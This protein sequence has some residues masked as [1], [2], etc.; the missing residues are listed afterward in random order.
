MDFCAFFGE[1]VDIYIS[2]HVVLV[3]H[4][5]VCKFTIR[6]RMYDMDQ[7]FEDVWE[8]FSNSITLTWLLAQCGVPR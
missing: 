3:I 4:D 7:L 1:A 6:M 5:T 2:I 8:T